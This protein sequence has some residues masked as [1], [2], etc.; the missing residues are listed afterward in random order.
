M[1]CKS[2]I[3]N[4]CDKS[5]ACACVFEKRTC[6]QIVT[7]TLVSALICSQVLNFRLVFVQIT[8][9]H[10]FYEYLVA[11]VWTFKFCIEFHFAMEICQPFFPEGSKQSNFLFQYNTRIS[12][13]Q[14]QISFFF[15][16]MKGKLSGWVPMWTQ[17]RYWHLN[18]G[19]YLQYLVAYCTVL[20]VHFLIQFF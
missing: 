20:V 18:L 19:G 6:D 13:N 12:S 4:M 2:N 14:N 5:V 17:L 1:H 8:K 9:H 7:N 10:W 15:L 3:P 11:S 16:L